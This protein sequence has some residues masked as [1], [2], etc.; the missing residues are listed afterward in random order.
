MNSEMGSSGGDQAN[1]SPLRLHPAAML[2]GALRTVRRWV[3]ALVIPGGA[4]LASQGFGIRT[5]LL[6]VA[7]FI[8]VAALAAVWGFLAWRATTYM[9][10]GGAFHLR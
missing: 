2:I 1:N 7:G 4:F 9:V 5:I 10:S 8:V 6:V 3:G